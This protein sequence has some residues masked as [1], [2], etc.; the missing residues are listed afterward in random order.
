[1]AGFAFSVLDGAVEHG[2]VLFD[3][4]LVAAEAEVLAGLR[5]EFRHISGVGDVTGSTAAF[6]LNRWMDTL[7]RFYLCFNI[8]VTL[9]TK[10]GAGRG[11]EH[12][13]SGTVRVM[14]RS[15]AALQR[16]MHE[17]LPDLSLH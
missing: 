8:R 14:A 10:T 5:K 17:L 13:R 1:M 3:E 11:E 2:L 16:L 7:C 4:A 9:E 6:R 15:A 12:F